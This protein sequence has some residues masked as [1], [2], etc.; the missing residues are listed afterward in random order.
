MTNYFGLEILQFP[1]SLVIFLNFIFGV[2]NVER[3]IENM[4]YIKNYDIKF[5]FY[6]IVFCSFLLF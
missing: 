4:I 6:F 1:F 2:Y 5:L 3:R